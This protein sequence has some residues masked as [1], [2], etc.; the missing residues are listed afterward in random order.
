MFEGIGRIGAYTAQQQL[1]L[2]AKY[3]IKKGQ[4]LKEMKESIDR[5]TREALT[6]KTRKASMSDST[7]ISIIRQKLRQ[8]HKLSASELKFLKDTDER[9]YEKAKK[10]EEAREEL[11]HALKHAKSKEEARRALVQAQMK[12]ASEAQLDAKGAGGNV[13]FGSG[14]AGDFGAALSGAG[15]EA[16]SFEG[17]NINA[18]TGGEENASVTVQDA[19]ANANNSS[20]A[21]ND[22]NANNL[23][24]AN[25]NLEAR[26]DT[27]EK[28][29][30]ESAP[31][32]SFK[33]SPI[34]TDHKSDG[35]LPGEKYLFMLAAIQDEWKKFVN[36]NEYDELQEW[37]INMDEEKK[38]SGKS[39]YR[40]E[41][42]AADNIISY[43]NSPID[44]LPGDLLDLRVT[45]D[46]E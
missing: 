33:E 25:P 13:S 17:D 7:K 34:D 1:R 45:K 27:A 26:S 12:V 36:S 24:Q 21:P 9:L 15:N 38:Q 8:G 39:R 43:R 41:K 22:N 31:K 10:A 46:D 2:E 44:L 11:Q 16:A 20:T 42:A 18:Q 28:Y 14:G 6:P 5:T 23:N 30:E 35:E 3:K 19:T 4:S 40:E 37:D 32:S 29:S